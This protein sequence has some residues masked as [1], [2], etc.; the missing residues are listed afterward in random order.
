MTLWEA[1]FSWIWLGNC[2]CRLGS[3]GDNFKFFS[4]SRR[5]IW[6]S[7][8][9]TPTY[10]HNF[11]QIHSNLASQSV[12]SAIIHLYGSQKKGIFFQ[13]LQFGPDYC[14]IVGIWISPSMK[15]PWS[16][17]DH[18]YFTEGEI[19]IPFRNHHLTKWA[20]FSFTHRLSLSCVAHQH[21]WCW[22]AGWLIGIKSCAVLSSPLC[23]EHH[24]CETPVT[25][26][27][28]YCLL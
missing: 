7:L 18:G 6:N 10:A 15:H 12:I 8:L 17:P 21:Y 23:C 20:C 5:K 14:K 9:L 4:A 26:A 16:E 1:R 19:Q 27:F 25:Q 13:I 11:S 24:S 2:A 22:Q 28:L 3:R